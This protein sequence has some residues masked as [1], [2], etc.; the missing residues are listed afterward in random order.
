MQFS[1]ER[2]KRIEWVKFLVQEGRI[3]KAET[4]RS[5]TAVPDKE[6]HLRLV[7]VCNLNSN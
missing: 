7:N 2:Q 5:S 3:D 1:R 6:M 4:L